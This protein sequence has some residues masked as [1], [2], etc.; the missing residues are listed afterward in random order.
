[1]GK[2]LPDSQMEWGPF[3]ATFEHLK[4]LDSECQQETKYLNL[5]I[6]QL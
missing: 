6:I 4:N 3:V 1:M 2:P 5:T